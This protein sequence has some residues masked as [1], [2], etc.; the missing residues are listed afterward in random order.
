MGAPKIMLFASS[1]ST[2]TVF[3]VSAALL[4]YTFVVYPVACAVIGS[5][6]PRRDP[7]AA[8]GDGELPR[9]SVII[10]ALDEEVVI[11]EKIENT[12]AL[13]Y[14]RR[15][16]D[17]IVVNDGSTDRTAAIASNFAEIQ[18]IT[19]PSRL[20]KANAMNVGVAAGSGDIVCFTDA[21]VLV[22]KAALR[23]IVAEFQK[24]PWIG[25]VTTDVQLDSQSV[26]FGDGETLFYRLER[27]IQ[28]GES[29]LG[30]VMGVDGGLYAI[31]RSMYE[32]LEPNTILDD[33]T[34]SVLVMRKG[35]RIHYA[36]DAIA[37]ETATPTA[38]D[39]FKRRIRVSAGAIQSMLRGVIPL[40]PVRFW[41]YVSH[42]LLRW[43]SP[44]IWTCLLAANVCLWPAGRVYQAVLVLQCLG[45]VYGA[46]ASI[47]ALLRRPWA[48]SIIFYFVMS[49][50]GIVIGV[51][52]GLLN[53]ESS[54]WVRT[55]RLFSI[56]NSSRK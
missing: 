10:P 41:Q 23:F 46:A 27:L 25:A 54:K 11:R 47:F 1:N 6:R 4:G 2:L 16:L 35:Y 17:I 18:L 3:V 36:P 32:P 34:L 26:T 20:G 53:L 45:I 33:F 22:D 37:K 50:V 39:E 56:G 12:L 40:H 8:E 51:M 43:L 38:R 55:P 5:M 14:P 52:R 19:L 30:G 28:T 29:R 44:F 7:G 49:Q 48:G 15:L 24:S 42:K 9:I 13:D 31:R 21:N